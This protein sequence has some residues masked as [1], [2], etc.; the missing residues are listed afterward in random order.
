MPWERRETGRFYYSARRIGGKVVKKYMGGGLVGEV[1][2]GLAIA[3]RQRRTERSVT[4]A[5][6]K[7]ALTKPERALANLDA[8]CSLAIEACL[9]AAGYH[10]VDYK[11]RRQR[12]PRS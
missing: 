8:A 1:A 2:E 7:E 6:E 5:A 9:T 10:R 11:W 12:V 3:S 4:I